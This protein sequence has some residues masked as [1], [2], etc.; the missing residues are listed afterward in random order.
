LGGV[1]TIVLAEALYLAE[2]NRLALGLSAILDRLAKMGGFEIAPFDLFVLKGM[3]ALP[4]SLEMHDR[5]ILATARAW[6]AKLISKDEALRE[7][8]LVELAW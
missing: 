6:G 7:S 2:K 1:P 4:A 5:I 3:E 8:G